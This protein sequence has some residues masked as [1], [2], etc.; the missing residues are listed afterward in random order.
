MMDLKSCVNQSRGDVGCDV[1]RAIVVN[2]DF[3]VEDGG[4]NVGHTLDRA[5]DISDVID[6]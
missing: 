5:K 4:F 3:M 6:T 1:L 2:S